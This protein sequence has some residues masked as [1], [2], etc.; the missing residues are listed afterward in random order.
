MSGIADRVKELTPKLEREKIDEWDEEL[1]EAIRQSLPLVTDFARVADAAAVHD[2]RDAARGL[3]RGFAPLFTQ[4]N[5]APGTSGAFYNVQFDLPKFVGHELMV[6][7]FA[8]LIG[9][10]R[11]KTVAELCRETITIPSASHDSGS[12]LVTFLFASE[13]LE[14]LEH[15][16][17]RLKLNRVSLHADIL[18]ERHEAGQLGELSPWRRFQD[19]DIFLYLRSVLAIR[20][21]NSWNR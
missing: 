3:F 15:R 7:L 8:A 21:S 10:R 16:N 1:V 9:E 20:R 14:L 19:S 11:W 4:Y 6:T 5:L 17:R 12:A 2:S 13:H 18:K